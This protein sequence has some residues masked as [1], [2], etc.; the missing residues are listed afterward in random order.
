M[1][2]LMVVLDP[3]KGDEEFGIMKIVP[4][5]DRGRTEV[6]TIRLLPIQK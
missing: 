5:S 1:G 2:V 4:W 3:E 6:T